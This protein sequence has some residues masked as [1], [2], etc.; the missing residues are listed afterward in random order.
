MTCVRSL[1]RRLWTLPD[2][3]ISDYLSN[4]SSL[5]PKCLTIYRGVAAGVFFGVLFHSLFALEGYRVWY[6]IAYTQWGLFMTTLTFTLLFIRD[7]LVRRGHRALCL[8]RWC[9]VLFEVAWTSEVVITLV[10]WFI[11]AVAEAQEAENYSYFL[12][13]FMLETHSLP[14]L[15]LVGDFWHNKVRFTLW[16]GLF[17]CI[18]VTLYLYVSMCSSLVFNMNAYSIVTWRDYR[19]I[20][21][22]VAVAAFFILG[23]FSGYFIGECKERCRLRRAE[24][25]Q[26]QRA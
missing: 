21:F 15:L 19:T 12:L 26:T 18:P 4:K 5:R 22:A 6:L 20:L 1:Q 8:T 24:Q 7:L 16:H 14:L 11:L 13:A 25:Y 17:V 23:F 3:S 2:S 10:F 9:Y